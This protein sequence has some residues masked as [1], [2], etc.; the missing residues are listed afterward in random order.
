MK[1]FSE[2]IHAE[3]V[4]PNLRALASLAWAVYLS[5]SVRMQLPLP[6][7]DR[8]SRTKALLDRIHASS[9]LAG[10]AT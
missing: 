6:L 10:R 3:W 9:R 7:S 8:S 1:Q 5:A 4:D 2:R